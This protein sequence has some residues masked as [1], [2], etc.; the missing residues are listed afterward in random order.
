MASHTAQCELPSTFVITSKALLKE[1]ASGLFGRYIIAQTIQAAF[2]RVAVR[3][4]NPAFLIID[5]AAEYV[6]DNI[7]A[8]LEQARK[9]NL[10]VVLAHQQLEQLDSA[11]RASIAANTSIK[12][13]G[14]VSDRDARA[15]APD[16]GTTP[17]FIKSLRKTKDRSS[18]ACCVRNYTEGALS[19][20]VSFGLLEREPRMTREQHREL[21]RRNRTRYGIGPQQLETAVLSNDTP[22]MTEP[23]RAGGRVSEPAP[24]SHLEG[25]DWR[26]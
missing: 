23:Q 2:E 12:F 16:M 1:Q 7:N 19:Y 13:A 11:L 26:S 9:Y 3:H 4:R 24:A 15:L 8:L 5:E 21:L 22:E 17:E 10:G 25:D 20:P 14:G 6:D 18:F